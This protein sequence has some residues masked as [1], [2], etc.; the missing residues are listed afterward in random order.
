MA[1]RQ[2]RLYDGWGGR[3]LSGNRHYSIG[4]RFMFTGSM[5]ALVTPFKDGQVDW[6]SL[7]GLVDFH[8]QNGT[9]GIVPCGTTG[10]SATLSHQEHNDVIRTV[11]KAVNQRVP[12]IAGTGSN[13]TEEAVGLTGEAEKDRA[14]GA[15]AITP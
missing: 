12:V 2:S 5:V 13:S 1:R 11:I 4:D 15:L 14:Q 7:A 3:S 9:H 8:L 6:P 10:E